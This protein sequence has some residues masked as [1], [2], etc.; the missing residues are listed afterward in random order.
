MKEKGT[1]TKITLYI[2]GTYLGGVEA[3]TENGNQTD[4]NFL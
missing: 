4:F 3:K 1:P 2:L